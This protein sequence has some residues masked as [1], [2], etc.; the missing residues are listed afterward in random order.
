MIRCALLAAALFAAV[1]AFAQTRPFPASAL[2]GEIIFTQP[3]EILLNGQPARLAPGARIR[4]TQNML[5]LTGRVAGLRLMVNYTV[6][7][8]GQPLDIWVLTVDETAR[9]P[10]PTTVE[11]AQAWTFD[12]GAQTWSK[13]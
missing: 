1:P 7:K 6:D 12:P 11:Q 5:Q 13:P 9:R 4:D 8:L 10:W 3:P 2:R